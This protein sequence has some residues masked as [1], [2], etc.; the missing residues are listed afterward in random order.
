[1]MSED[2]DELQLELLL[3][4]EAAFRA[5]VAML[6]TSGPSGAAWRRGIAP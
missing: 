2:D 1:M 3:L 6:T 5:G 4:L